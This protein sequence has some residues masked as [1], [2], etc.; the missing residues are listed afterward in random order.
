MDLLTF[1]D[2]YFTV[3]TQYMNCKFRY[4]LFTEMDFFIINF[5]SLNLS[6]N[7]KK[8]IK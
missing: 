3:Y 2:I 6:F 1:N 8:K 7:D 4:I 5:L